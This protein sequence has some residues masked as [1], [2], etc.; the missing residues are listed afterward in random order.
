MHSVFSPGK[1]RLWEHR[2]RCSRCCCCCSLHSLFVLRSP[3]TTL[4]SLSR[5]AL[6]IADCT[7]RCCRRFGLSSFLMGLRLLHFCFS[8]AQIFIL[9]L[10][11]RL[12]FFHSHFF[13]HTHTYTQWNAAIVEGLSP[14]R[15]AMHSL[16]DDDDDD[17]GRNF[18]SFHFSSLHATPAEF[19]VQFSSAHSSAFAAVVRRYTHT[20]CVHALR[21]MPD[22]VELST[23]KT[24][25]IKFTYFSRSVDLA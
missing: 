23:N 3:L 14:F 7:L 20:Q 1:V 19:S 18:I 16:D 10:H 8:A 13:A 9:Y 4:S 25:F 15:S 24:S 12:G 22:Q 6:P 17:D 21:E 5:L 2:S 11:L